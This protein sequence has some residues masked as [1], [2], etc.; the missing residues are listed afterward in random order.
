MEPSD[1][2]VA[3]LPLHGRPGRPGLKVEARL[4][5]ATQQLTLP[6]LF[7]WGRLVVG[8]DWP[9]RLQRLAA[10]EPEAPHAERRRARAV[11]LDVGGLLRGAAFVFL[12][13]RDCVRTSLLLLS[14][15]APTG[16]TRIYG[17]RSSC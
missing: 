13:G 4:R 16:L 15:R 14:R 8:R 6:L 7:A 12:R 3:L 11:L 10:P 1:G 17:T 5:H 2:R 9:A